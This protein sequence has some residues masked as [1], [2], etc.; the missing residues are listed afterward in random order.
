MGATDKVMLSGMDTCNLRNRETQS[1]VTVLIVHCWVLDFFFFGGQQINICDYN[2]AA[3]NFW[4]GG[5]KSGG[6]R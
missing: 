6:W 3:G 2:L 5:N 4:K 1:V